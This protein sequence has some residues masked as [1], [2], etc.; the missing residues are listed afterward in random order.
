MVRVTLK[1]FCQFKNL[2]S[3][4]HFHQNKT[5]T[6]GL[7]VTIKFQFWPVLRGFCYI[8]HVSVRPRDM[9]TSQNTSK[10]RGHLALIFSYWSYHQK[11]YTASQ[12]DLNLRSGGRFWRKPIGMPGHQMQ[13]VWV[14]ISGGIPNQS[15]CIW[16]CE[17]ETEQ[18]TIFSQS[19]L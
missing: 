5:I 9:F 3:Y 19:C 10:W 18:S 8:I 15:I 1:K 6:F 4:Y 13:M 12:P 11:V 17:N 2:R 7:C 16:W 14:R